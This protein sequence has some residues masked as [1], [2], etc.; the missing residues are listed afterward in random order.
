MVRPEVSAR[1][2]HQRCEFG[3]KV[4]SLKDDL[5]GSV[6][7]PALQT[8]QMGLDGPAPVAGREKSPVLR[9]RRGTARSLHDDAERIQQTMP[10]RP[11]QQAG[12]K[13]IQVAGP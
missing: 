2:G 12:V 3:N 5:G 7:P 13:P 10:A 9:Q 8:I 1:S 6:A 4:A 11:G